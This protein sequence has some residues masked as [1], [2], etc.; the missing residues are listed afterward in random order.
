MRNCK[1]LELIELGGNMLTGNIPTWIGD[2][3]SH[4]IVLSVKLNDFYGTIP[5]S[6]CSLQ[7]MQVLDL[8]SNMISGPIPECLYNL[9]AMTKE[10][11]ADS[12][13]YGITYNYIDKFGDLWYD[14]L[15]DGADIMW[16]GKEVNYVKDLLLVKHIDLSHN[17]LV[18]DIPS[19]ITK[20]DG[21]VNLNLS[22]N[23]LCGQI[24]PN[25]GVLKDLESLDLSRNQLSGSIP[26]SISELGSLGVLDLSYNNLSG[27]IPRGFTKFDESAY[28]ENDGLCGRPVL[29][30]SC[31]GEDERKHQDSNFNNENNAMNNR[32]HEDDEFITKGFYICMVFGF[33]IGFWGIIGS[34]LVSNSARFAYFKLL[35][36]I[37][38]FVYVRVRLSKVRFRNRFRN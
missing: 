3:L 30:K 11:V 6:I 31:P 28:A 33:V 2:A 20:L 19:E 13:S 16:K 18:G 26:L 21:L 17:L 12:T 35:N 5:L 34:I 15:R 24:P 22:R 36:T 23:H 14:S 10:V 32:E 8:S 7:N 25:I 29:D 27:R 37:E 1:R 38:N 4:L 9:S